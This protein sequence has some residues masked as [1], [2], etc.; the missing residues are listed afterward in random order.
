MRAAVITEHGPPEVLQIRDWPDPA[1]KP[2]EV[3]IRV[4]A[5]GVNF[6]DISARVGLY[7]DAPPP[8]CV[9]G[10]EVAGTIESLGAGVSGFSP[11]DPV[12]AM[13]M[14]GGYGSLVCADARAVAPRPE[15]MSVE[16]AAAFPVVYLTAYHMLCYMQRLHPTDRVLIHAAAGG[17]GVAAVQLCRHAGVEIYATASASKHEFL[18]G[19]G[20]QHTIDYRT[21]D[22]A[23][24]IRKRTGG[25]GVDVV[26]DALG[27]KALAKSYGLLRPGGRLVTYGFSQAVK[28]KKR[29][30]VS[31]AKEYLRMPRF[32]WMDL[33][34]N[35]VAVIGVNM[36]HMVKRPDVIAQEF[37]AILEL[38]GQGVLKPYVDKAFPVEQAAAAHHYIQDRKNIGKVVLT[39]GG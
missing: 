17:V 22:F 26:L 5:A 23:E 3:R 32:R 12:L 8:P 21:E 27:G 31:V 11:G 15:Q 9:V 37:A 38:Y 16:E 30:L 7:P 4:Q 34:N 24:Q 39:Y 13:T 36:A 10:Y 20:V 6:A 33:M 28:D 25:E 14:F 2:G 19:L 29:S 1:P 18:R 35:N